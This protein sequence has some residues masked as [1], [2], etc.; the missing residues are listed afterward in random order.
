MIAEPKR[1]EFLTRYRQFVQEY[2]SQERGRAHL[3][4]YEPLRVQGRKNFDEVKQKAAT[5]IVPTDDVLRKLLPHTDSVAHREAGVWIH[6]AP[7]IQGDIKTWF[8]SV[9]WREL[10]EWPKVAESILSFFTRCSEEPSQLAIACKEFA[11]SPYSRGLQT[12]MLTPMLN[13]LRPDKFLLVN[14]KSRHVSNHFADA[15]YKQRLTDYSAINDAGRSFVAEMESEMRQ[16]AAL[17]ARAAD[18]FDVFHW[19]I[20]ESDWDIGTKEVQVH[21]STGEAAVTIAED[22]ERSEAEGPLPETEVRESHKIQTALAEIGA[23]LGFK[24]WIPRNDRAKVVQSDSIRA[25]LLEEL[26]LNYI[27]ATLKTI[28]QIDVIWIRKHLIARAF[29][30]EHTTSVYSGLL[31]MA[32]LLC[33][34]PDINIKLHI[35]APDIRREKVVHEI[36]RP[37]FSSLDNGPLFRRCSFIAYSDVWEIKKLNHLEYM[38]DQLINAYEEFAESD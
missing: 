33:L 32:D 14:N 36:K 31:R 17:D 11:S 27:Y 6:T 2:A 13:A 23:K 38:N 21:V 15:N 18:L 22:E 20:S 12:G 10:S 28:E 35:V 26:P 16:G 4:A 30:V 5:G 8:Q 24:I 1:T 9:G 3:A 7:A 34:Q 25:A 37:I 19:L 29:E